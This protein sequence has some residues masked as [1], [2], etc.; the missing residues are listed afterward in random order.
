VP[1]RCPPEIIRAVN[2]AMNL[3][4]TTQQT[5]GLSPA[6]WLDGILAPAGLRVAAG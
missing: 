2:E 5:L 3:S 6:G 4:G 1:V